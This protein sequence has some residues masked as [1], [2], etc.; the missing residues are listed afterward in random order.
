M[1]IN[2]SKAY[3]GKK[4]FGV[5]F[6]KKGPRIKPKKKDKAMVSMS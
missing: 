2:K 1:L 4:E 6:D 5:N 3:R